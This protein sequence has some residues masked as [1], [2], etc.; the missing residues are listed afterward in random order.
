[1]RAL[2][3]HRHE[4]ADQLLVTMDRTSLWPPSSSA[5]SPH[6]GLPCPRHHRGCFPDLGPEPRERA[7]SYFFP[8]L[9]RISSAWEM[10]AH[11]QLGYKLVP[12]AQRSPQSTSAF[13]RSQ[14]CRRQGTLACSCQLGYLFF[15]LSASFSPARPVRFN[16]RKPVP[17][18]LLVSWHV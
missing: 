11:G 9:G 13:V 16:G 14:P 3:T 7:F 18:F 17:A 8:H 12:A 1:M 4:R 5:H 15:S 6:L 10:E 2:R